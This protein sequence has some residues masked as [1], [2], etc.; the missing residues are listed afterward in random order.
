MRARTAAALDGLAAVLVHLVEE[1]L[2]PLPRPVLLPQLLGQICGP[3]RAGPGQ[4][5][6]GRHG[7]GSALLI[8]GG[9]GSRGWVGGRNVREREADT[10]IRPILLSDAYV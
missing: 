5:G 8:H 9:W 7:P 6:V 2:V 10:D 3:G 4:F 1:A